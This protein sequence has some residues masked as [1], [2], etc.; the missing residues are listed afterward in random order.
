[1]TSPRSVWAALEM[2]HGVTYFTPQARDA[3]EAVG[4]RGFWRGYVA[5]RSA[6]LGAASLAL[7]IATFYN[8]APSF[9]ER[10]LP[11]VWDMASPEEALRAREKGAVDALDSYLPALRASP[12]LPA[13]NGLL[14]R[15]VEAVPWCGRPLG[16]ANAALPWPGDPVA[17]LWHASTVLREYR[18]DGH[19]AVLVSEGIDGL[20]AHVLRDAEDGS[21]SLV[22]PNRGWTDD[23]WDAAAE[24]LRSRGLLS[25]SGLSDT[26][27]ALR[28]HIE[29]RTDELS[30]IPYST[31]TDDE[32]TKVDTFLRPLAR[33]LAGNPIPTPN[34]IGSPTP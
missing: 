2:I 34:P 28:R 8:F 7:G 21:R 30:A 14:H 26:G 23:E 9:L 29:D 6:P 33:H 10:S 12:E 24:R 3:H 4:L 11:M 13:V 17:A 1:M 31:L 16:S 22:F 25:S 18:G 5:M 15:V 20:E 32:L 27:T 19:I